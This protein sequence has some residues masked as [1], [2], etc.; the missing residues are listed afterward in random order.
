M[1]SDDEEVRYDE[2]VFN[3]SGVG[4]DS[5]T[6]RSNSRGLASWELSGYGE[7]KDERSSSS[8]LF[9]CGDEG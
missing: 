5:T 1:A 8:A 6:S 2:I 3:W 4:I 9:D 7:V